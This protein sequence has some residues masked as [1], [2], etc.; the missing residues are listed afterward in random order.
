MLVNSA[1]PFKSTL[2]M[3][4]NE[5][6]VELICAQALPPSAYGREHTDGSGL[7]PG[8]RGPSDIVPASPAVALRHERDMPGA[9]C[10]QMSHWLALPHW[11]AGV[12][13]AS[14]GSPGIHDCVGVPHVLP[15]ERQETKFASSPE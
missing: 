1:L 15:D 8:I 2:V 3:L 7:Y 9:V 14:A 12:A 13:I 4:H 5:L 10:N 6:V 11:P